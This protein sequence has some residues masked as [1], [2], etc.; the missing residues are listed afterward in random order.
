MN[1]ETS[2]GCIIVD[3]N[4]ALIITT[5]DDD[6]NLFSSFPKGHQELGETHQETALRE[7]KEEVGLDV[8]ITDEAPIVT[9]HPVKNNTA[10]KTIYFFLAKLS[11][12]NQK[13]KLQDEEV[14]S[15]DW[16]TF[17]E[18]DERLHA[19]YSYYGSV[20]DAAK[21]RLSSKST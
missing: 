4:Q 7:V 14:V 19:K 21:S 3:N 18:A 20:W 1:Q 8:T 11:N 16:L 10:I 6:G 17:P 12:P 5:S 13:L 9:S 15:A 2:C